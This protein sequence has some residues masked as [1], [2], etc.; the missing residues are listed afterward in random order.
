MDFLKT[1]EIS[2]P[3][4]SVWA[5]TEQARGV[6]YMTYILSLPAWIIFV[7]DLF[8]WLSVRSDDAGSATLVIIDANWFYSTLEAVG[9]ALQLVWAAAI[10]K[11]LL[12]MYPNRTPPYIGY[13]FCLAL[14]GAVIVIFANNGM[15]TGAMVPDVIEAFLVSQHLGAVFVLPYAVGLL[16]VSE[17]LVGAERTNGIKYWGP[18]GL[19]LIFTAIAIFWVGPGAFWIKRRLSRLNCL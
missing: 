16:L 3:T 1:A 6:F 19:R 13:I 17:S 4:K 10:S 7:L 11:R 12:F 8:L 2:C 15:L 18:E 9:L 5:L 14:I